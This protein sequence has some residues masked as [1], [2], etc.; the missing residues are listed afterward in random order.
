MAKKYAKE[1]ALP[2]LKKHGL[3]AIANTANNMYEG[4][5]AFSAVKSALK[6]HRKP[7]FS[8]GTTAVKRSKKTVKKK[9]SIKGAKKSRGFSRSGIV[10]KK[11]L[12]AKKKKG[13]IGKKNKKPKKGFKKFI[14]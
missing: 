12:F 11:H 14:F 2:A 8:R 6:Q 4:E 7:I 13:R 3:K 9:R 1:K 10:K 5:E